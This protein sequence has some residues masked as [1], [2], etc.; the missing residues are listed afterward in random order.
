MANATNKPTAIHYFLIAFVVL[1]I[2]L[3]VLWYSAH[4]GRQTAQR[5]YETARNEANQANTALRK[6]LDD[7]EA[8]KRLLGKTQELVNDP[9]NPNSVVGSMQG[10]LATLGKS[11]AEST[12]SGTMA[13]LRQAVDTLTAELR[14]KTEQLQQSEQERLALEKR[15]RDI[16]ENHDRA[17]AKAEQ[18]LRNVINDRDQRIQAKDRQIAQLR[19]EY[20]QLQLELA[21]EKEARVKERKQLQDENLRLVAIND[22]LREELNEVRR[23]S[24]DVPDGEIVYVDNVSQTVWLNLGD[25]DFLK[26]RMTFSVYSKDNPGVGRNVADIKGKIEVTRV[27]DGH[28]S[29]AKIVEEDPKRPLTPGDFVFTPI[30]SPGFSE[31]FA[32]VGVIDMDRD[33]NPDRD[34]FHQEMQIRGAEIY[35]E[36][37]DKGERLGK[38]IDES[39]K[40]LIVAGIPDQSEIINDEERE[41][42]RKINEQLKEMQREARLHGVR[43]ITL[44]DFLA[45]IGFKPKRRIF[46]PGDNKAYNL[47][48]GSR[49]TAV[50]PPLPGA[51]GAVS[52][53]YAEPRP[54]RLN[55]PSNQIGRPASD[56]S[57]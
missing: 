37:D 22:K 7:L 16:A 10:D 36:V 13:R 40:F 24:F 15:Y 31:R 8:V 4:S 6:A 45:Y 52:R 51:E 2:V 27:L 25:I 39:V 43:I 32:I 48:G 34:M 54:N 57:R 30:W 38:P 9:N 28:L 17:K 5:N 49:Q 19:Q 26:P 56:K 3:G 46:H 35:A 12:Y 44:S 14:S 11:E 20:N 55:A 18:D 29:E 1:S 42:A 53:L 21:Q 41:A 50:N 23:E 47:R 33:G